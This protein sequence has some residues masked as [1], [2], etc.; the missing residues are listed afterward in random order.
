MYRTH[1]CGEL[2]AGNAGEKVTLAGWVQKIRTHGN[3]CFIDLRDRYGVTQVTFKDK[4]AAE[5]QR[6]HKE[7]VIQAKGAVIKKPEAN[8]ALATGEVEV[9]AAELAVLNKAKPLPLDLDNPDTTEETRLK[10][11]YLDL[12]RPAMQEK[13]MLR[14]KAAVA[15]REYFDRE[16]F[17][18]V[19][20]PILGKSTPEGARDYLVPSRVNPGK[21]YA[22]PQSPQ[23]FKQLFQVAGLDKYVQIVK[24]FRDEDLRADR[25]PEFTQIDLEMSFV[26]EED[27]YRVMEGMIK[28]VWK[29]ALGVDV[30]TPFPRIPYDEAM[31]RYG[32]DKPDLRFGL[33]LQDV[34]AWAHKTD[35][36]I[37]K[38]AATVRCL[39]ANGEFSRKQIDQ[40][41]SVVKTYGAAGLLT[42]KQT[43]QGLEGSIAKHVNEPPV[44]LKENDHLFLVAG[45]ERFVAPA[46]GALRLHLG[47]TQGLIDKDQWRFLWVTDFPLMDWSEEDQRYV[48]MH[49]PFTSPNLEDRHLL[50]KAPE[51]A[52][53]RAYDLTLNGVELGG[54]SIR[55]HDPEL[56]AE[57]FDALKISKE[58]Q[59]RKFGFLLGAL[60]YG[61]PPHG[62]IAFGFDRVI[63]LLAGADNIREVI[64][65]PKTKDAEDLMMDA[66]NTVSEE[67]LDELGISTKK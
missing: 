55:I 41:T 40:L 34:T 32:S 45:T 3:L 4:L 6:L 12:R 1:T 35:F 30:K 19:E 29:K 14:S 11:R 43:K 63:M 52:R 15:V 7:D 33:E 26:D 27:I 13:L 2:R 48:A 60:S 44:P 18:E 42:L 62:G 67:Q 50:K 58:E 36:A 49:H 23:I 9:A 56:Q 46:L 61:A 39:K 25:Q 66:P 24:C 38:E 22:L 21:F 54:G 8:K 17:I 28:H 65:F 64:A 47:K 37:F 5:A 53:S 31:L 57:V 20:T 10:Y 59:Q 16:G 51:K